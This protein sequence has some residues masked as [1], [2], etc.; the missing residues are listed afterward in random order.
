MDKLVDY[1][2]IVIKY[3]LVILMAILVVAVFMQVIFRFVI[4]QPL[5][6]TE[7]LARYCL[8]WITFLGAAFAMATNSHIGVE[9]FVKLL[10]VP[11]RRIVYLLAVAASLAFFLLLVL[12]GY[13]LAAGAMSQESPVLRIPMGIIYSVIPLSGCIL[14]INLASRLPKDFKSGGTG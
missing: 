11:I 12:E 1:M 6:W 7:E 2:N 5:A 4:E 8:I 10:T 9:F 14:I 3:V 13:E